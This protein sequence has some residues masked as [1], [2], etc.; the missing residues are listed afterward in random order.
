MTSERVLVAGNDAT[1]HTRIEQSLCG[2]GLC[3]IDHIDD[4]GQYESSPA[5]SGRV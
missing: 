1:L 5:A 2:A 4:L 3:A